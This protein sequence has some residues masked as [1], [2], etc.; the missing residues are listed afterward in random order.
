[1]IRD[2]FISLWKI[3]IHIH[4]SIISG[5]SIFS[6]TIA[7]C[8]WSDCSSCAAAKNNCFKNWESEHHNGSE[9]YIERI[10]SKMQTWKLSS[11]NA[12]FIFISK[13]VIIYL[14]QISII[15]FSMVLLLPLDVAQQYKLEENWIEREN[16]KTLNELPFFVWTLKIPFYAAAQKYIRTIFFLTTLLSS[17]FAHTFFYSFFSLMDMLIQNV[18]IFAFFFW[19]HFFVSF[20]CD[21]TLLIF[22]HTFYL[23]THF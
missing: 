15:F 13:K 12:A 18:M 3:W 14:S 7:H 20:V 16:G 22:L 2:F 8:V 4:L 6:S 21:V 19:G 9:K 1:M 11:H 17:S 10:R 23:I 5:I